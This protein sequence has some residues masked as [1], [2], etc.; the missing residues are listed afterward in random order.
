[1][2]KLIYL[3]INDPNVWVNKIL[4]ESKN[5]SF[6]RSEVNLTVKKSQYDS[7]NACNYLENY[8]CSVVGR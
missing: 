7:K 8:Y 4:R 1:M 3:D 5:L 2:N 6:Q